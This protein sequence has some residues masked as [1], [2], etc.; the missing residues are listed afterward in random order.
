[1]I[2]L[3]IVFWKVDNDYYRAVNLANVVKILVVNS[4][5]GPRITFYLSNAEIVAYDLKEMPSKDQVNLLLTRI[6]SSPV[7][8]LDE[9]VS[10]VM[11][12]G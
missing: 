2:S 5:K 8:D 11:N 9:V 1:M 10:E 6:I 3:T 4:V 12:E 7:V